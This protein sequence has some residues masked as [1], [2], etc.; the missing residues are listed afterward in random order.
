MTW[1]TPT[2]NQGQMVEISYGWHD[3]GLYRRRYDHSTRTATY[4]VA[5]E[6]SAARLA[7]SGWDAIN[8]SPDGVQTWTPSDNPDLMTG[9][10][11]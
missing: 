6:D 10:T 11:A 9:E 5:D 4:A 1:T 7:Q 3:G 2:E 8:G